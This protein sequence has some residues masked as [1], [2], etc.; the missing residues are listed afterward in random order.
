MSTNSRLTPL[1]DAPSPTTI[2][3]RDRFTWLAYAML[4]YFAYLQ[5]ALGPAMPFLRRELNL[6]YT[7]GGLH[8]SAFALGMIGAGLSGAALAARWGRRA[9]FWGGAG[10][11]GIGA[12]WGGGMGSEARFLLSQPTT[13]ASRSSTLTNSTIHSFLPNP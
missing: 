10:G 2:F 9:I 5:S 6:S 4:A 7:L 12:S 13:R 11:M 1:T 3:T 8:L